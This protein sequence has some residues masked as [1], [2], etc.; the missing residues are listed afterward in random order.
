MGVIR[1]SSL[2]LWASVSCVCLFIFM[3]LLSHRSYLSS[4]TIILSLRAVP[5]L[6]DLILFIAS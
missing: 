2:Y 1:V 3:L 4:S 6:V 5:A